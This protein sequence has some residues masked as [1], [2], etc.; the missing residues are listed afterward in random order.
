MLIGQ[1]VGV[2]SHTTEH[3]NRHPVFL[4]VLIRKA[5]ATRT[6]R[7]T[8]VCPSFARHLRPIGTPPVPP[9]AVCAS[10]YRPPSATGDNR[11]VFLRGWE[12]RRLTVSAKR[13]RVVI[14]LIALRVLPL[15][16]MGRSD[17]RSQ[18]D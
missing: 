1:L 13:S 8:T 9:P 5:G 4:D 12:L 14:S 15:A 16:W 10:T 18:R 7:V 6:G 11:K 3:S 17:R 2:A